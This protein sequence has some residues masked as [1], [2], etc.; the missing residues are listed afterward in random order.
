MQVSQGERRDGRQERKTRTPDDG[1]RVE[2]KQ[3]RRAE[4]A[5]AG[6]VGDELN[7]EAIA[8]AR[9]GRETQAAADHLEEEDLGPR[10]ACKEDAVDRGK[11]G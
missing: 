1:R 8:L 10:R 11:V 4:Q 3:C 9:A 5:D 6:R 7:D 2:A